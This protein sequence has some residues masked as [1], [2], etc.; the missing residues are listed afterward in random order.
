MAV[1]D[2]APRL[3][4]VQ[5]EQWLGRPLLELAAGSPLEADLRAM[6][7][8]PIQP[9]TR[10]SVYESADGLCAVE[11]RMRPLVAADTWVYTRAGGFLF[12]EAA[13]SAA[14]QA[15]A[16]SPA[17]ALLVLRDQTIRVQA[18]RVLEQRLA[19][20]TTINRLARTANAALQ[21]QDIVRAI[22]RELIQL[23]PGDRAALGLLSD[24]Q[25]AGTDTNTT[26]MYMA[27]DEARHSAPTLEG[28]ALTAEVI[29]PLLDIVHSG[30]SQVINIEDAALDGTQGRAILQREG[31]RTVVVVPLRSQETALGVLFIGHADT[32]VVAPDEL[33]L[34]ETIGALLTD[35][36]TRTQLYEQ[37]QA[38]SR[39]KSAFLAMVS[40]ELRTPL[41][42]II[43][44]TD[45]LDQ[46]I[47]GELAE[48]IVEPVGH[49]RRSGYTLLNMINDILDFSKM[50]A[51]R[52]TVECYAVDVPTVIR[53]SAEAMRPQIQARG[54]ELRIDLPHALPLAYANTERLE[55]VVTNLLSNAVKFTDHGSITVRVRSNGERVHLSV[56]DTGIGIA[57]EQQD[58]LFQEFRQLGE[59]TTRRSSGTGLGLAISRRL[60]EMMGGRLTVESVLGV[61]STF[62]CELPIVSEKLHERAAA[63][64]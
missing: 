25:V 51:G 36:I 18:E 50:E 55:Q 7:E 46:G 59:Q 6:L 35:A 32:R 15:L 21:T 3:L 64:D 61:G 24:D 62:C 29:A 28:Q 16:P 58:A 40:H 8:A 47:F 14:R 13:G 30:E 10:N 34:L 49:I 5:A 63:F 44:F 38:A 41:T 53:A 4:S 52:F 42:S 22:T 43:G 12:N 2:L 57:I 26:L 23:L 27:I 20:L 60:V 56:I 54:L 48:R 33:R 11:L 1:N 19:E 17:G 37:A 31:L 9:A 45:M 39:T